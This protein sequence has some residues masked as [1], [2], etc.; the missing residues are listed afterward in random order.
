MAVAR[1]AHPPSLF[2]SLPSPLPFTP[3]LPRPLPHSQVEFSLLFTPIPPPFSSPSLSYCLF[4]PPSRTLPLTLSLSTLSPSSPLSHSLSLPL[5]LTPSL[6]LP[7]P[8]YL[9]TCT[10]LVNVTHT[11]PPSSLPSGSLTRSLFCACLHARS[12]SFSLTHCLFPSLSRLLSFSRLSHHPPPLLPPSSPTLSPF[13]LS[14][15]LSRA[16]LLSILL[17]RSLVLFLFALS[18]SRSL[19]LLFFCSLALSLSRSCC[20]ARASRA[21]TQ[22]H[23]PVTF[24]PPHTHTH[25][26]SLFFIHTHT[27]THLMPRNVFL[28]WCVFVS[29]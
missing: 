14:P 28:C 3:S 1:H 8:P 6:P 9:V 21:H 23:T 15:L 11:H 19:A 12:L 20:H 27:H 7:H 2:L 17:A 26:R 4:P 10:L 22:K 13:F 24:P 5:A 18:L 16:R 29:V 25:T